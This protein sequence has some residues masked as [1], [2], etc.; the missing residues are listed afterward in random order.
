MVSLVLTG[1]L[2]NLGD[3]LTF[4]NG[5]KWP[6]FDYL[7]RPNAFYKPS[8]RVPN[9]KPQ[10]G[11]GQPKNESFPTIRPVVIFVNPPEVPNRRITGFDFQ[12]TS[13]L[14]VLHLW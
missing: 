10:R 8:Q 5:L 7:K 4:L 2:G 9:A 14:F 3:L 6:L 12:V 1:L 13:P 11:S